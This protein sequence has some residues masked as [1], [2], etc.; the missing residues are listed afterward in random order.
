MHYSP[1]PAIF[2]E[3]RH[4]HTNLL[5][6]SSEITAYCRTRGD[7]VLEML[8]VGG[9]KGHGYNL[10]E[11][12]IGAWVVRE[13]CVCDEHSLAVLDLD[14]FH[15]AWRKVGLVLAGLGL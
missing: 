13:N 8:L 11:D 9:V 1:N 2:L 3:S 7:C 15:G 5:N 12:F 10:D 14:G 6:Y 4:V